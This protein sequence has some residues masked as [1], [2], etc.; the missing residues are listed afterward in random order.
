MSKGDGSDT[1]NSFVDY[2]LWGDN[3]KPLAVI[4]AKRTRRDAQVGQHQA[5]LY[6]D[7]LEQMFNQERF[8]KQYPQYKGDFLKVIDNKIEYRYDILNKFK[9]A[10]KMP[11]MAVSVDMLD[12]GID[13]PEVVNLVFFKPIRSS[14]KY[15][16][17]IG[18]GTRL[19]EN[20]FGIGDPKKHFVIFDFCEN[21]EF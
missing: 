18:R 10:N 9:T 6:A 21:F 19:C 20:L 8:D 14:T 11:Q 17:M 15:W 3:G 1:G 2:V 13:I 7:C 4:E 5:K 12:T 16:Q